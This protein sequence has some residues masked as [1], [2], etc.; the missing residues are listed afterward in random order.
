MTSSGIQ[1]PYLPQAPTL[2]ICNYF[3]HPIEIDF[4]F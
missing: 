4:V 3:V 2:N 1:L